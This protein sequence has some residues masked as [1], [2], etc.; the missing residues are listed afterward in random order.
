MEPLHTFPMNLLY[1]WWIKPITNTTSIPQTSSS[2]S[3]SPASFLF[4]LS[5]PVMLSAF[6]CTLCCFC[7]AFLFEKWPAHPSTCWQLQFV[8]V[9]ASPACP[10]GTE[11]SSPQQ[12]HWCT[13]SP[14]FLQ[15]FCNVFETSAFQTWLKLAGGVWRHLE[16]L[17]RDKTVQSQLHGAARPEG[18]LKQF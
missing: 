7:L 2:V 17:G 8:R 14:L 18:Y 15:N 6:L 12:Q 3:S 1:V 4:L 9:R 5:P 13:L 16:R 10:T 11:P